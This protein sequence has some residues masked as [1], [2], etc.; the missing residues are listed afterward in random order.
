[1]CGRYSQ[2]EPIEKVAS[3]FA[4]NEWVDF[5]PRYN[6]APSQLAPVIVNTGGTRVLDLYRWGLI[7]SWAKEIKIG[8]KMINARCETIEEKP[9]Y[10]RLVNKRRCIVPTDGFFEWQKSEDGK[11]KT[12]MRIMMESET[13]FVFAGLWDEW[14]DAEG[15][16]LRSYTILT[17]EANPLL[18]AVHDRMPVILR[19]ELIDGWLD[20]EVKLGDLDGVFDPYSEKEM[21]YYPVSSFVNSPGNEGARCWERVGE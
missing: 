8:Y 12:P 2:T 4:V 21:T 13:P 1:M 14:R 7:P 17:T 5:E 16:P 11:S 18:K 6:I 3:I 10:R 9:S 20:T 19:P 15:Q